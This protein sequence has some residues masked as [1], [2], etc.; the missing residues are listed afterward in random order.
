MIIKV[1]ILERRYLGILLNVPVDTGKRITRSEKI[2]SEDGIFLLPTINKAI[3]RTV[4]A[5]SR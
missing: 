1:P 4:N 5:K 3:N 2:Q